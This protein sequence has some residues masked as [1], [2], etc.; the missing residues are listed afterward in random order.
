MPRRDERF[1]KVCGDRL[2][3]TT[4]I[5][6]VETGVN[7]LYVARASSDGGCGITP[8]LDEHGNVVITK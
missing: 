3:H 7:Y 1:E 5:R 4:V 2:P 8:L 6:D